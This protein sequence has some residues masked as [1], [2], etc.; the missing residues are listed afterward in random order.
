MVAA[1]GVVLACWLMVT[2]VDH[3]RQPVYDL[4][5]WA[6]G[7]GVG[8]SALTL[9]G[10]GFLLRTGSLLGVAVAVIG[11]LV[12]ASIG[13][14]PVFGVLLLVGGIVALA[15]SRQRAGQKRSVAG[16]LLV[17]LALPIGGLVA[18]D[19]PVVECHRNGAST[20]SSVF[21]NPTSSS[22]SGESNGGAT[23]GEVR[24]GGRTY[25]YRCEG[26]RLVDFTRR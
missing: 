15:Q 11:A 16:G 2:V 7:L 24:S 8:A 5:R 17:A 6:V 9:V 20:S 19:G 23:S 22:G 18:T 12:V 25:T 14:V 21:R 4:P 13:T 26:D 10:W 3:A 1:A